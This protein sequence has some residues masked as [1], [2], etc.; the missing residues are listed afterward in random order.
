MSEIFD[1]LMHK[2]QMWLY[3]TLFNKLYNDHPEL[4]SWIKERLEE[5]EKI[6]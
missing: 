4:W 6:R 1:K 2:K 3:D 5:Y